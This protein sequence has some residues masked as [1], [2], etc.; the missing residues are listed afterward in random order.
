MLLL[1]SWSGNPISGKCRIRVSWTRAVEKAF[2]RDVGIVHRQSHERKRGRRGKL[3]AW[4]GKGKRD[5][6]HRATTASSGCSSRSSVKQRPCIYSWTYTSIIP[7][8]AAIG[9]A[10]THIETIL[11]S[12]A[13]VP[14]RVV[15]WPAVRSPSKHRRQHAGLFVE[16][17]IEIIHSSECRTSTATDIRGQRVELA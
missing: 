16:R 1:L 2:P 8:T 6:F 7:V 5:G 3:A 9:I 11:R 10:R 17:S 15:L 14:V 13:C 4:T 12:R